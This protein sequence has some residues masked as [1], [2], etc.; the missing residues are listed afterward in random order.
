M[1]RCMDAGK[2][3]REL[4]SLSTL[5]RGALAERWRELYR[6]EPPGRIGSGFLMSAIAYRLQEQVLGSLKP[7]TRRY[8][9]KIADNATRKNTSGDSG[10]AV[11]KIAAPTATI[12]PG[13]RLLREWHGVTYEVLVLENGV[14]CNG[15]HYRSL[16]EVART[17][18][19]T[20][21]SGPLFFGLKKKRAA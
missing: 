17:I 14:Q 18:T 8:L 19:G 5:D 4:A 9:E 3:A 11:Q 21:W 6:S 1:K 2:L 16:S 13:T 10:D 15:A 20:K 7:T 12:K